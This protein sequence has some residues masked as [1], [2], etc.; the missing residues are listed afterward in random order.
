VLPGTL[1]DAIEAFAADP[2]MRD[3]LGTVTSDVMVQLKRREWRSFV[4]TVTEWDRDLY[5]SLF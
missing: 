5:L 2:A 4:D 1:G 3:A